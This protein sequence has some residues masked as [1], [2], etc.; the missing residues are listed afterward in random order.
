MGI[1]VMEDERKHIANVLKVVKE[2][3]VEAGY[4]MPEGAM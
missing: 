3:L 2:A 4:T 1:S